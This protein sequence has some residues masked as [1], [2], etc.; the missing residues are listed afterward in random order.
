MNTQQ[1]GSSVGLP[2]PSVAFP[3]Q[4]CNTSKIADALSQLLLRL[5]R[6]RINSCCGSAAVVAAAPPNA[7]GAAND[8][9]LVNLWLAGRPATTTASYKKMAAAFF[10][11]APALNECTVN[12]LQAF[13]RTWGRDKA[14][15]T[16]NKGLAI[17]KSL[18]S[19]AAKTGYLRTGFN[20][21]VAIRPKALAQRADR[22]LTFGEVAALHRAA[23]TPMERLV[24][25]TLF[26]TG[27]R[28]SELCAV[29][30]SDVT[31]TR[32]GGRLRVVGKGSKLRHV[33]LAV[34]LHTE[35]VAYCKKEKLAADAGIFTTRRGS[36]LT[37]NALWRLV[38]R[39][40]KAAGLQKPVSV[41][42]LR[43][44]CASVAVA[45]GCPLSLVQAQL[46]HSSLA[47]TGKYV[48]HARGDRVANYL[49]SRKKA[50]LKR[51]AAGGGSGGG[52]RPRRRKRRRHCESDDESSA[53]SS[54]SED[55][56]ASVDLGSDE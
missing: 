8:A 50:R 6:P 16:Y 19:Y 49:G 32:D 18:F 56:D 38:K 4:E 37:R 34:P 31:S 25:K 42:W 33:P 51:G 41:H 43:H 45:N 46:G 44:T 47:T 29:R 13:F 12:H 1:K 5:P 54:S 52:G 23:Q 55:D 24:I 14:A 27:L 53:V 9:A 17:V 15:S 36:Q 3:Q 20:V 21:A 7:S 26:K 2:P 40:A 48:H 22:S 10:A 39:C 35:L 28:A 30:V 11:Q